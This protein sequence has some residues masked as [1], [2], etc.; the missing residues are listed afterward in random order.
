MIQMHDDC[1]YRWTNT[2]FMTQGSWKLF[3]PSFKMTQQFLNRVS[4]QIDQEMAIAIAYRGYDYSLYPGESDIDA[5]K[6]KI[7][8][9]IVKSK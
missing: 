7:I 5:S 6:L 2:H 3:S 4:V 9:E 1:I 8:S